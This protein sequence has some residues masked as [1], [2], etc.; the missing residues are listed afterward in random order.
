MQFTDDY[1]ILENDILKRQ[2]KFYVHLES[3]GK[4]FG[5]ELSASD[6]VKKPNICWVNGTAQKVEAAVVQT[7][8]GQ[9]LEMAIPLKALSNNGKT[10]SIR[11]NIGIMD[12]DRL[13]N[14]KP[15]VLWWRP[16]W[17]SETDY[18]ES[19]VFKFE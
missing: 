16:L 14:T 1:T 8:S 5:I 2:D 4:R 17:G 3:H 7:T 15:S 10:D 19:G 18:Q 13:E 6:K 12:H 11:L 9:V